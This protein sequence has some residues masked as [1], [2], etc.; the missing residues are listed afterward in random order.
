MIYRRLLFIF[1][2]LFSFYLALAVP[3]NAEEERP[4]LT[5]YTYDSF[6]SQWGPG[7][8]IKKNFEQICACILEWSAGG[9]GVTLLNR[10]KL[11]GE[12]A[13][14]DIVLGLD[15]NLINEA[16]ASDLFA[17]H[18]TDLGR[19][20]VPGGFD[21]DIFIPYDYSYFAI[22]YDSEKISNPPRS[23]KDL[24]EGDSSQKIVLQDPRTST[25]GLGMLLWMK[26]VYGDEAASA[27]QKLQHRILTVTPGWSASYSLF[28]KGEVPMVLSYTTSAAY[29]MTVE[30]T[31]RYQTII[32]PEGHYLH[33]EVAARTKKGAQNPLAA[34]FLDF[35]LSP[36]FQDV[37]APTNWMYPAGALSTAL[38]PAFDML[39]KPEK[40][41]LFSADEVAQNRKLWVE[42][43][44]NALSQ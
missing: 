29:H 24:I 11:E 43:W 13:R 19:L 1:S 27:W 38:P 16:R 6:T 8:K 5:I 44:L 42:E 18:Q 20:T 31:Q 12:H 39:E 41:W 34:Q 23:L 25:P 33:I 9:D 2:L 30:K 22:I 7:E 32:Y 4:K 21:D 37:I 26:A 14:A 3:I 28:T 36:D 17:P 40:T 15:T 10:L 35:M